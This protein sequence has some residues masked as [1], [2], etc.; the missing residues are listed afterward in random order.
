MKEIQIEKLAI[1]TKK[2]IEKYSNSKK[3]VLSKE[4][5]NEKLY[6]NYINTFDLEIANGRWLFEILLPDII[7]YIVN[8]KQ[9]E[10][11]KLRNINF[12]K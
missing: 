7:E 2:I 6:V 11:D 9:L 12:N 3:I 1:R 10:A 4:I 8:K 5:Q